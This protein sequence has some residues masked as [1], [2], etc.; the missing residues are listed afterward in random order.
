[1]SLKIY[2]LD[3]EVDLLDAFSEMVSSEARKV[4]TF[5]DPA[6]AIAAAKKDRPDVFFID[7][8]LPTCTGDSVA[9]ALDS[10]IFKILITG[11][12]HTIPTQNFQGIVYKP[13]RSS[14]IEA[15]LD[16][17]LSTRK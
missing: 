10:S 6:E 12:I 3:D 2:Y 15:V 7:Y 8:R 1:M 13:F 11:E 14:D 4:R 5:S 16:R 9:N 17:V